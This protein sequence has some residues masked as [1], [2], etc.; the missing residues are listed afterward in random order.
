MLV[1]FFDCHG[2]I[3]LY[4]EFVLD[5]HS[6][7]RILCQEILDRFREKLH[8]RHPLL[9]QNPDQWVLQYGVTT[10]TARSITRYPIPWHSNSATT[11]L[12]IRSEPL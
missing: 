10:Y 12:L 2:M 4:F 9:W 3:Y 8:R 11:W 6:I 5:A 1:V 7:G